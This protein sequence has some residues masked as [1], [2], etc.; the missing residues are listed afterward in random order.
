[1]VRFLLDFDIGSRATFGDH[2]GEVWTY[3]VTLVA[4]L[5]LLAFEVFLELLPTFLSLF[6]SV[7][8]EDTFRDLFYLR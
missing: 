1:M 3:S 4:L 8:F 6:E 5:L 7:F 2:L